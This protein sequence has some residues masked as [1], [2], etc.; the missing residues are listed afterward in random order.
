M[1]ELVQQG[2]DR[3]EARQ[4]DAERGAVGDDDDQHEQVEARADV[5]GK[6][7]QSKCWL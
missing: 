1:T 4:P 7:E 2:E 6:A 5:H 3:H